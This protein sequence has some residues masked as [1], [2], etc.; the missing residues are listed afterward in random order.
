MCSL[1]SGRRL[2]EPFSVQQ[3]LQLFCM[4]DKEKDSGHANNTKLLLLMSK[5]AGESAASYCLVR[6][7]C[8]QCYR[9]NGNIEK[10]AKDGHLELLIEPARYKN[11]CDN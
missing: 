2:H 11:A 3:I 8:T 1:S 10:S 4:I 7:L 9:D 5:P 6:R